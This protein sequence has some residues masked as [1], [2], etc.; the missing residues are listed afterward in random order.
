MKIG[1]RGVS[2]A[3]LI[4]GLAGTAWGQT[5]QTVT[6]TQ[7]PT[8][9]TTTTGTDVVD[10]T[11][12]E[13]TDRV[14]V[15]GSVTRNREAGELAVEVYNTEDFAKAGNPNI[16][17]FVQSLSVVGDS[18]GN[19]DPTLASD[20][21]IYTDLYGPGFA[22]F[23]LR[24]LSDADSERTLNL[25][26]GRRT[27]PNANMI[28][29]QALSQIEIL[30]DGASATYGAGAVG[31]VVNFITRKDFEGLIVEG[32]YK[33]IETAPD[34]PQYELKYTQGGGGREFEPAADRRLFAPETHHGRRPGL[35]E[36]SV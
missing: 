24:G 17:E 8:T 13:P 26:N 3:A 18:V 29:M 15:V 5:P 36:Q 34:S 14:V 9:T 32:E 33:Y 31:G 25:L 20:G 10:P 22:N 7:P 35:G 2:G 30:K 21:G 1:F 6:T 16:V 12:E 11:K 23:N 19:M 27:D 4:I 28:P